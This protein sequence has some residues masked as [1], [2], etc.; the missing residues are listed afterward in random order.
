MPRK[1]LEVP[2]D[3]ARA[4][5]KIMRAYFKEKNAIKRDQIAGDAALLFAP[6]G[7]IGIV[8]GS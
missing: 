7:E 8:D 5:V 6:A 2:A 3:V 4:F 1:Q